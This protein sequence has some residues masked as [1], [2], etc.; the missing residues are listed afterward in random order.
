[1]RKMSITSRVTQAK[2][3]DIRNKENTVTKRIDNQLLVIN[4]FCKNNLIDMMV[5]VGFSSSC[6][7]NRF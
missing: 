3:L 1:M 6:T 7:E 2:S 4:T 5:F